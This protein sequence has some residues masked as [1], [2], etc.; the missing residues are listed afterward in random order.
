M[1]CV[2]KSAKLKLCKNRYNSTIMYNND[3]SRT[4]SNKGYESK[5]M[6]TT[7]IVYHREEPTCIDVI[8]MCTF[9]N[10]TNSIH[11]RTLCQSPE[12]PGMTLR[13]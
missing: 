1:S 5:S 12:P 8:K 11:M 3:L 2:F 9:R 4:S 6:G 7:D 10:C 13:M